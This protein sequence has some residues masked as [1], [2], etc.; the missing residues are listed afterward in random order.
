MIVLKDW[1][2]NFIHHEPVVHVFLAPSPSSRDGGQLSVVYLVWI[3]LL[4]WQRNN[5][6]LYRSRIITRSL[7]LKRGVSRFFLLLNLLRKLSV[8]PLVHVARLAQVGNLVF[9]P[10]QGV[11][12]VGFYHSVD[13]VVAPVI[14]NPRGVKFD[15]ESVS[16]L[17]KVVDCVSLE[18]PAAANIPTNQ[19]DP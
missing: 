1:V 7:L 16:C 11:V 3:Y 12:C 13:V 19:T 17:V 9:I 15:W 8:M 6:G 2:L 14:P 5:Q 18:V 4:S 10:V